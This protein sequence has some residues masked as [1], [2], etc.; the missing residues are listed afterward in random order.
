MAFGKTQGDRFG[1]AWAAI[2]ALVDADG[3]AREAQVQAL[4]RP[5]ATMR[6]LADATHCLCLL[7][8][9]HP[10]VF[11]LARGR[12]T[13]PASASWLASVADAFAGERATL[14]RL[15][16]AVGPLPSTPGQAESEAAIAAQLHAIDMLAASDRPGCPVG[17]ALALLLDWASVRAVLATVAT[18]SGID[19]PDAPLPG[20][21]EC[22]T[23]VAMLADSVSFE[24]AMLFGAQQLLAQ[25]RA[26]WQLL[27]GRAAARSA[28]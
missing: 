20:E 16:A 25:H 5:G 8:G 23:L 9:R 2:T 15:V 13:H 21:A 11:D 10:G 19:L 22:A 27:E 3:S 26:L 7:H 14:V 24:R 4:V 1:E 28:S 18:R 12:A 17:A 6:D